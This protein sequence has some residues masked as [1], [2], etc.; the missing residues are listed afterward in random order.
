MQIRLEIPD[1]LAPPLLPGQDPDRAARE[2]IGL[3]AYRLRRITG[4]QLRA[5]LG[6]PSRYEL[7]CFL[8]KHKVEKY[9]VEDFEHDLATIRV[10]DEKHKAEQPT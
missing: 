2:A 1:D 10:G 7:D 5:L 6:I 8:K 9:T 4:Y 3:E